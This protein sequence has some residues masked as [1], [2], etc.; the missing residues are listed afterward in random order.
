MYVVCKLTLAFLGKF[1]QHPFELGC[2]WHDLNVTETYH[3][4]ICIS[5]GGKDMQCLS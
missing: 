1:N 4:F 2:L 3:K 5:S